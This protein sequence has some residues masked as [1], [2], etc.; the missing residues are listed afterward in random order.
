MDKLVFLFWAV[1]IFELFDGLSALNEDL[2]HKS[3]MNT[4][5]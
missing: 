3:E 1:S 5:P 2:K 4:K